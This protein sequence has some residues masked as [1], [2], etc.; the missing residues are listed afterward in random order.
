MAR[1]P[2]PHPTR[3][4]RLRQEHGWHRQTAGVDD[5][6]TIYPV[7]DKEPEPAGSV[8]AIGWMTDAD[9]GAAAASLDFG[10]RMDQRER[11]DPKNAIMTDR[12]LFGIWQKWQR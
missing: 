5:T 7:K 4:R 6:Q 11:L 12:N 1:H 10:E 8:H 9:D 3:R 2:A